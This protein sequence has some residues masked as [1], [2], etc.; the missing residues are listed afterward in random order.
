MSRTVPPR[1]E[2]PAPRQDRRPVVAALTAV[3]VLAIVVTALRHPQGVVTSA[4]PGHAPVPLALLL[5]PRALTLA[6]VLLLPRGSGERPDVVPLRPDRVRGEAWGLAA[7]AVGFP[8][9][10]PL[11]PL[12]EDYVLLKL[13][14]FL[15][16]PCTALW[17]ASRRSG[18]SIRMGRPRIGPW[19][20]LPAL[21]L[22]VLTAVGPFSGGV[23]AQWPPLG[24]LLVGA[25][26]TA[27]TASFGEELFHRRLLQSRLEALGGRRTGI[28][29]ASLLFA[30]LHVPTHADG[31]VLDGLA[32]VIA[33]QGTMGLALGV[34]WARWRRLWPCVLAH[35][36]DNG[37]VVVLHLLGLV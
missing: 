5:V 27:I 13:V 29:L 25:S 33:V 14:M 21:V 35:L 31:S 1:T 10:V 2:P 3:F 23:P 37:L 9:L 17:L 6:L 15:L 28:A 16:L 22:G 36:L 8:L 30:L 4:D 19:A 24:M 12:P 20:V 32:Q 34:L 26:A 18:P 11:L 7:L